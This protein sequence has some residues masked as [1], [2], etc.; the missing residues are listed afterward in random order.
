MLYCKPSSG[1]WRGIVPAL[2]VERPDL[3]DDGEPKDETEAIR[4]GC[5]ELGGTLGRMAEA[6]RSLHRVL[7]AVVLGEAQHA[8]SQVAQWLSM[9]HASASRAGWS[10][11]DGPEPDDPPS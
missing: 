1:T 6:A 4:A 9:A 3:V 7:D 10:V 8:A 2:T 5:R 11:K